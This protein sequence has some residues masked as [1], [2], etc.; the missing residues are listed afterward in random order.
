MGN[1]HSHLCENFNKYRTIFYLLP[2][3]TRTPKVQEFIK[4]SAMHNQQRASLYCHLFRPITLK[5]ESRCL[6]F[7]IT[8]VPCSKQCTT[9]IATIPASSVVTRTVTTN[10]GTKV[11]TTSDTDV[12]VHLN[13]M[14]KVWRDL[15]KH[16]NF[17]SFK[18]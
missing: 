12:C 13:I 18:F 5:I 3:N 9:F 6:I 11:T 8:H 14:Y 10:T 1:I 17:Q 7:K 4:S 15:R 16:A 2:K